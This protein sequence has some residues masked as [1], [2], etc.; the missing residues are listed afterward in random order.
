MSKTKKKKSDLKTQVTF[1]MYVV[2][3]KVVRAERSW[4]QIVVFKEFD[5]VT[6]SAIT[7]YFKSLFRAEREP[8][9]TNKPVN[10]T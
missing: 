10:A 7:L 9:H 6:Q 1:L 4:M 2:F 8:S 3:V 5:Y